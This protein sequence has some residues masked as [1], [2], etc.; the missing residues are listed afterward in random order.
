MART[1]GD[2]SRWR[3]GSETKVTGYSRTAILRLSANYHEITLL[4]LPF[5]CGK[6]AV[7]GTCLTLLTTAFI[8]STRLAVESA[9]PI[10]VTTAAATCTAD[11]FARRQPTAEGGE[12]QG[13][14]GEAACRAA[15]GL[16]S[17]AIG[18]RGGEAG[19]QTL[20]D[21]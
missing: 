21:D 2:G 4:R 16:D 7:S 15:E 5:R 12:H 19:K 6:A 10:P 13:D 11:Q 9:T 20:A 17:E 18:E 8:S 14:G 1:R 3:V